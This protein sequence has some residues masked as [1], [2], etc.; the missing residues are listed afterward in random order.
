VAVGYAALVVIYQVLIPRL[1]APLLSND[2]LVVG[3]SAVPL[4]LLVFLAL[5]LSPRTAP[6]GNV[7]V[8]YLLGVGTAV[9]IGGTLTGTLIPQI[10]TAWRSLIP[11]ADEG[12]LLIL[13]AIIIVGGAITT[14]L[15]FQFWLRGQTA[16]GTPG[17]APIMRVLAGIGQGF[18][19]V[20]LGAVYGGMILSGIAILSERVGAAAGWVSS[21]LP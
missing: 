12:P 6:L 2:L 9:A 10:R 7:G 4:I 15:Y 8:A 19:M 13:N 14:L 16:A 20:T 3:L 1:V 18:V 11:S 21:I 5:K 17:R